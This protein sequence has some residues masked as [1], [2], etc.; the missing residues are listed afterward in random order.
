MRVLFASS[1]VTPLAKTGGL[2]DV[3]AALPAALA[4]LG[5]D[6][7]LIVPGYP[8][9]LDATVAKGAVADLGDFLGFG[10]TRLVAGRMPDTGLSVWLV[11]CPALFARDGGPYQDGNG[12]DW[13]DNARRFGLFSHAV[14]RLASEGIDGWHADL[15]HANDWQTGL[16]PLLL[17]TRPEPR[18]RTVFTVHNMAFQGVFPMAEAAALRLPPGAATTEGCEYHGHIS[19]LK[20]GLRY[21][22]RLTTVSPSYAS[23]IALPEY[24]VGLDG[25]VRE[26]RRHLTGILNGIDARAWDPATDRHLPV[27]Y[28]PSDFAGKRACKAFVQRELGLAED[29]DVPLV[30]FA[31]RLT[32]QKMADVIPA[33]VPAILEKGGQFA[34][35]GQGDRGIAGALQALTALDRRRIAVRIG[36][37][38]GLAHRL[39]SGADIMLAPARYEPCG[40][41]Q[42]YAMRYGALPV[43]RGT[44]GLGDTVVDA[45]R[46]AV[47]NGTATGFVFS[48]PTA[49]GLTA[50]VVRAL[51]LHAQPILW[52]KVQLRAM[53]RDFGWKRSAQRYKALYHKIADER[54][55]RRIGAD[56]ER[57]RRP[58]LASAG[59]GRAGAWGE[60]PA[61][62]QVEGASR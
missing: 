8:G 28:W 21:A 44:G 27:N 35:L 12:G 26:R 59:L 37:D 41:V 61:A 43:V 11:D 29:A 42:L 25:V 1:E 13:P 18:P 39:H 58:R 17:A 19:L 40:L 38:E 62:R 10:E 56:A 7:T 45:T 32:E 52:R 20:S 33:V 9:A 51:A 3:S 31:S 48:E 50:A 24:G 30:V 14:A 5:L 36:Y 54:P 60:E 57:A 4:G 55:L 49:A 22:D 6:M 15:V 16:V 23:E 53:S 2:A 47:A 46:S 34:L